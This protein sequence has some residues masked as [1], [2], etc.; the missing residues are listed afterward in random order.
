MRSL[1]AHPRDGRIREPASTRMSATEDETRLD[2]G[3]EPPVQCIGA[4]SMTRGE[5]AD[6]ASVRLGVDEAAVLAAVRRRGRKR[7]ARP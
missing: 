4:R 2:A 5:R 6:R 7:R 1:G 3:I